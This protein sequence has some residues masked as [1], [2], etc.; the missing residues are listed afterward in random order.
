MKS[1]LETNEWILPNYLYFICSEVSVEA[2]LKKATTKYIVLV[3]FARGAV[4]TLC[5]NTV[6]V[7]AHSRSDGESVHF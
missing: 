2:V 3:V 5:D 4:L 1:K 7:N 6:W